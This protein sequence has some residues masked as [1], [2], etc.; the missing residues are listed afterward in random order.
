M[1]G[2][3]K[4]H[5]CVVE[6]AIVFVSMMAVLR[7]VLRNSWKI[8]WKQWGSRYFGLGSRSAWFLMSNLKKGYGIVDVESWR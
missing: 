2:T 8:W 4:A 5:V 7:V 1:V 6:P 3:A